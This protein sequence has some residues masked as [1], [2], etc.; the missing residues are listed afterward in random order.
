MNALI[1]EVESL[2]FN[3]IRHLLFSFSQE[4]TFAPVAIFLATKFDAKCFQ[5][6]KAALSSC[7][8]TTLNF[9]TVS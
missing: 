9:I 3:A 2:I 1:L 6:W 8:K 5:V 7:L 4:K